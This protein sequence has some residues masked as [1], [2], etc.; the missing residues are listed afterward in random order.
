MVTLPGLKNSSLSLVNKKKKKPQKTH[1][2]RKTH[3]QFIDEHPVPQPLFGIKNTFSDTGW[4]GIVGKKYFLDKIV[5]K[6]CQK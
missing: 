4:K 3:Q 2:H 6:V 5:I 1:I